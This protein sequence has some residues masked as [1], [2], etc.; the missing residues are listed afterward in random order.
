MTSKNVTAPG[1]DSQACPAICLGPGGTEITIFYISEENAAA[2][3]QFQV[4][5]NGDVYIYI[6]LP[7]NYVMVSTIG[8]Y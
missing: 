2:Q 7:Q 6:S 3:Y 1:L 4:L 8:T 5:M